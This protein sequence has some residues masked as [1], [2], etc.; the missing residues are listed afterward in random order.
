MREGRWPVATDDADLEPYL[1]GLP[2]TCAEMFWRFTGM[3]RACGPITFEL[4]KG[5]IVLCGTRRIFASVRVGVAGLDGHLNLPREITDRRIVNAEP[6]TKRLYF[7]RYRVTVMDDLDEEFGAWVCEARD[8][9]DGAHLS[10]PPS[11]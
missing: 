1:A 5:P 10:S 6:L 9:G 4:Q 2:A 7:H 8:I 3:A 11:A